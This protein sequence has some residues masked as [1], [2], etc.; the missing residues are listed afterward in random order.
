MAPKKK[1]DYP[2]FD[3]RIEVK[4]NLPYTIN[5]YIKSYWQWIITA[6]LLPII[7]WFANKWR[8]SRKKK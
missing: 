5:K 8:K 4:V 7:G 2:V 1:K 3:R 6:V